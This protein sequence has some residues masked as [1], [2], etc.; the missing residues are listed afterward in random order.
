MVKLQIK[1]FFIFLDYKY[2]NRISSVDALSNII[3]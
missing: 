3:F 1:P 2:I